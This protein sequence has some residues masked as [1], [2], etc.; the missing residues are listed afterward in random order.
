MLLENPIFI[1]QLNNPS[2]VDK[3][4]RQLNL[5]R[6]LLKAPVKA[7]AWE[8]FFANGLTVATGVE[9]IWI[10]GGHHPGYDV[11]CGLTGCRTQNKSG[12]ISMK[13]G[14]PTLEWSGHRTTKFLTIDEK[15]EFICQDHCDEYMM[16]ARDKSEW[17]NGI[18]V[19]NV[20]RIP[21]SL[22][23]YSLLEWNET[24]SKS[25]KLTGWAGKSDKVPYTAK[26]SLSMSAQLWTSCPLSYLGDIVRIDVTR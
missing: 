6:D 4:K 2:F 8:E 19:Y 21:S 14:I 20:I 1:N 10:P 24:Y 23:D 18:M 16:L 17:D 13:N 26:I 3:V 11:I 7:E 9:S 25:G 5:Y 12:S 22:I 15:L